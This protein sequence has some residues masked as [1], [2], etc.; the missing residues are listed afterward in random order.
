MKVLAILAAVLCI[1]CSDETSNPL[2]Y[3][4]M[5]PFSD[6]LANPKAVKLPVT[7]KFTSTRNPRAQAFFVLDSS[8]PVDL[9][10]TDPRVRCM[11]LQDTLEIFDATG[12]QVDPSIAVFTS[13]DSAKLMIDRAGVITPQRCPLDSLGRLDTTTS[14]VRIDVAIPGVKVR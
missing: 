6:M 10:A 12:R 13:A 3:R 11:I 9:P 7:Y 2:S 5:H 8:G 14:F 4:V 1:A